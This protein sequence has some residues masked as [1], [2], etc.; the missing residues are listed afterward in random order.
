MKWGGERGGSIYHDQEE[1]RTPS[2]GERSGLTH[3]RKSHYNFL[4]ERGRQT[5][6]KLVSPNT[7]KNIEEKKFLIQESATGLNRSGGGNNGKF[8]N[9]KKL[10]KDPS[11]LEKSGSKTQ[12]AAKEGVSGQIVTTCLRLER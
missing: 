7:G 2:H 12:P 8:L 6:K 11:A 4:G 9:R 5:E 1:R 10:G 3:G